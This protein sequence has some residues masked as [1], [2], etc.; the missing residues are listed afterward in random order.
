LKTGAC[1]TA[2]IASTRYS[3]AAAMDAIWPTTDD[4]LDSDIV[5]KIAWHAAAADESGELSQATLDLLRCG[6]YFGLPVPVDLGGRGAGLLQSAAVQRRLG[7]ADPALAIAVN[8]HLFSVGMAAHEFRHQRHSCGMILEV[9]ATQNR[10]IASAFAEPGLGGTLLRSTAKARRT[11]GGYLVSGV[12]SPCSLAAHCDLV[13]LQMEADPIEPNGL[14]MAVIPSK[15]EGIRFKRTWD[16]LGMRASGSDTLLLDNCFIPDALIYHRCA[17][18]ADDDEVFAAGLIWLCITTTATYLGVVQLALDVACAELLHTSVAHLGATR[19]A[20]P[21]VQGELGDLVS[22]LLATE[23]ACAEVAKN[24]DAQTHDPRNLVPLAVAIKLHAT[25]ACIAAVE[26]LAELVG[27]KSYARTSTMA[28]LWRDVQG[29]RFNTPTRL[30]S[31]QLLGKWTLKAP[32][33]FELSERA[34]DAG[35]RGAE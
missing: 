9:I 15:T 23:L 21:S 30:A 12:K 8:M 28:R 27:G 10:I 24:L 19:A 6:G 17:P 4:L 11:D 22:P 1:A 14:M 3:L 20:L 5:A 2:T 35:P 34:D 16:T 31:R 25:E 33:R 32:F 13:C 29:L 26:G 18:G 7:M